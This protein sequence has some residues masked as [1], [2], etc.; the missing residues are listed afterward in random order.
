MVARTPTAVDQYCYCLIFLTGSFS[1]FY[2]VI[3]D[4][5]DPESTRDFTS[6]LLDC[7]SL[8][9]A[10]NNSLTKI[11]GM[12]WTGFSFLL[13]LVCLSFLLVGFCKVVDR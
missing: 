11:I 5:L 4:S 9:P 8:L 2:L 3:R 10:G 13:D 1:D 7:L 6:R 12:K